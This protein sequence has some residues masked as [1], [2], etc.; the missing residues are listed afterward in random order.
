MTKTIP[1][2]LGILIVAFVAGVAGASVFFFGEEGETEVALE[3]ETFIEEDEIAEEDEVE[4]KKEDPILEDP[5]VIKI[6]SYYRKIE[7]GNLQGAYNYLDGETNFEEFKKEHSGVNMAE[8]TDFEKVIG[9][10]Y[11]FK[12]NT[13]KES[14]EREV[15]QVMMKVHQEKLT[16]V[17]SVFSENM[18]AFS[19]KKDGKTY[20][21]LIKDGEEHII[22]RDESPYDSGI[23]PKKFS[24]K[25]NY[26][27]S[28]WYSYNHHGIYLHDVKNKERVLRVDDPRSYGFTPDEEYFF[29]CTANA[30][31]VGWYNRVYSVPEFEKAYEGG[32]G[33]YNVNCEYDDNEEVI[34][35]TMKD[36]HEFDSEQDKDKIEILEFSPIDETIQE[37]TLTK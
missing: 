23:T 16:P 3:E 34:R 2:T 20:L 25:S 12:L 14:N 37:I 35:F 33:P 21:L 32:N 24:P 19:T 28:N 30:Y 7:E 17:S 8:P 9:S 15:D 6:K 4:E 11:R 29:T 36:F 10:L 13:K 31:F 1:T 27:L 5:S 26:L 22:E 18:E